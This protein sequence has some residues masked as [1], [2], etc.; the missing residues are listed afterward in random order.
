MLFQPAIKISFSNVTHNQL[1]TEYG[2]LNSSLS[3]TGALN[4]YFIFA[5]EVDP[6]LK[7]FVNFNSNNFNVDFMN[8]TVSLCKVLQ[9]PRYE[10]FI[11]IAYK[12]MADKSH[13][14]KTCPMKKVC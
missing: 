13:L 11:K 8:K 4:V 1:L 5:K 14:P 2:S 6:F 12:V 10:P 3:T 7:L 9:V